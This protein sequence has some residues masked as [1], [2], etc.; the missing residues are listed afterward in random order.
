MKAKKTDPKSIRFN[1]KDLEIAMSKGN[2]ESPQELVDCLLSDYVR[3]DV[4]Y[5][6]DIDKEIDKA[7]WAIFLNNTKKI[8]DSDSEN[9]ASE[10]IA[11]KLGAKWMIQ[12]MSS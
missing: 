4:K 10:K 2:F 1:I 9:D 6:I 3:E 7:K 11:F 12:Q 8:I 5:N